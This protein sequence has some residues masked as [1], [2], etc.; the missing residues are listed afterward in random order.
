MNRPTKSLP[1]RSVSRARSFSVE[2]GFDPACVVGRPISDDDS[3]AFGEI[4]GD[5]GARTP[6]ELFRDKNTR[7]ELSELLEVLDDRER[8][9]IFERFGLG[10]GKPKTL[11]EVGRR[12]GVTREHRPVQGNRT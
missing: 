7:D 4:V 3:T 2:V 8:K 9:I 10:G 5:E 1:K 6:F 12:F 11:E